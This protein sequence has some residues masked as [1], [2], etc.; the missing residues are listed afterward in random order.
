DRRMPAILESAETQSQPLAVAL[1]DLDHFKQINDRFGHAIGD[2][3]LMQ[4]AQQLRENTRS[5]D[6]LARIGGEEFLIV[7]ADM[8]TSQA[9]EVCERLRVRVAAHDWRSLAPGLAVT[10]SIGLANAPPYRLGAL[11]E[12]ADRA[13]Y[14]AKQGGRNRIAVG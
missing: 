4:I 8:P 10:L 12:E 6:V 3:V 1:V 7:F 11:F 13:M 9:M 5:S 2:K 14:R